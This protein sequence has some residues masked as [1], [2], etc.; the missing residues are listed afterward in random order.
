VLVVLTLLAVVNN[1][2]ASDVPPGE[3]RVLME[4][5]AST[6]GDAWSDR[7]GWGS[8]ASVCEWHGVWCD[9]LDGDATRPVVAGLS[10]DLNNLDGELPPTLSELKHLQRLGLAGNKLRGKLPEELLQRWDRHAFEL[11]A[12]YNAFSNALARVQVDF[13]AS[14]VLCSESEDLRYR[15]EV[16][17]AKHRAS[18]QSVRCVDS[19]SD[20]TFCLVREGTAPSLLRLSRGL[21]SLGFARLKPDYDFPFSG[22]THGVFL[23]TEAIWGDGTKTSVRTYARQGPIEVWNAQQLFLGILA[24]VGWDQDMK[25]PKCDFEQ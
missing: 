16:D 24:D 19:K 15:L 13:S 8:T 9:F 10:L 11:N 7:S 12:S 17:E 1:Q 3:R 4:L 6:R 2:R 22:M 21:G 20:K 25:K 5:Y 14:G 23:T 18:L